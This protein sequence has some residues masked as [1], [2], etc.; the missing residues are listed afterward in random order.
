MSKDVLQT[1]PGNSLT[2]MMILNR[3]KSL[4]LEAIK[5]DN[6]IEIKGASKRTKKIP[7]KNANYQLLDCINQ[8]VCEYI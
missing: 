6:K 2:D 3:A 4:F 1:L 7:N 5:E 8:V